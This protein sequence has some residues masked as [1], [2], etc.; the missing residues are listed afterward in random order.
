MSISLRSSIE[1]KLGW[2][3]S[4]QQTG[5][6]IFDDSQALWRI[7]LHEGTETNQANAVWYTLS[8]T[9]ASG[10]SQEWDLAA[11]PIS[12][13]RGQFTRAFTTIK[14]LF[15]INRAES[16]GNL[17]VGGASSNPWPGPFTTASAVSRIV[18]GGA[19][20]VGNP[21]TGWPVTTTARN[22]KLAAENGSLTYDLV[23]L[24]IT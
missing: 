21:G 18:P 22:L 11:L 6:R 24:G 16:A 23:L 9:L 15:V 3:W 20:L 19:L 1:A 12:V 4:D 17:L 14:A 10:T 2:T 8:R 5:S 13:F 7:H